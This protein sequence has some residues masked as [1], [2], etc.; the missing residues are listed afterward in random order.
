MPS[1]PLHRDAVFSLEGTDEGAETIEN[2]AGVALSESGRLFIADRGWG[3]QTV[4]IFDPDGSHLGVLGR[5]E[6]DPTSWIRH[7]QVVGDQLYLY[8]NERLELMVYSV[9]TFEKT[10]S[11]QPDIHYREP[12]NRAVNRRPARLIA[13]SDGRF[14]ATYEEP[15]RVRDPNQQ[16][17]FR[18]PYRSLFYLMHADGTLDD[19]SEPLLQIRGE[20]M[21]AFDVH[22]GTFGIERPTTA[23]PYL[24]LATG[25][26][27]VLADPGSR[28]VQIFTPEGEAELAFKW[29]EGYEEAAG[30]LTDDEGKIWMGMRVGEGRTDWIRFSEKGEALAVATMEHS[31][32]Q[33]GGLATRGL[34][35]IFGGAFYIYEE[36][37]PG[38][39]AVVR[40]LFGKPS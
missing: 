21:T 22:F 18:N 35:A 29:P 24:A 14:L 27:M 38:R 16:L 3:Q 15:L 28:E 36:E 33:G 32:W 19:S 1:L 9:D 6:L 23:I 26:R 34:L 40:Y 10:G 5:E 4:H 7:I 39:G 13:R 30:L 20:R 31:K 12:N 37:R 2:P 25:D 8:D 17:Q 11:V